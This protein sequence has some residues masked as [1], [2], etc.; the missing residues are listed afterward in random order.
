MATSS[1]TCS[2]RRYRAR[3]LKDKDINSWLRLYTLRGATHLPHEA[4]FAGP[5]DG[6]NSTWYE[7]GG[8]GFNHDGRGLEIPAWMDALR[9]NNPDLLGDVPFGLD[10]MGLDYASSTSEEGFELQA[11][12][13]ADRW[14]ASG[15]APPT[16]AVDGNLV[17]DPTVDTVSVTYPV[18]DRLHARRGLRRSQ[19]PARSHRRQHHQRP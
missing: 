2:L 11:I 18:A 4:W 14:A 17:T 9:A 3:K 16:S 13:N 10:F 19:L 12:I 5:Y 15:K 6:G 1:Q 7:F 8:A